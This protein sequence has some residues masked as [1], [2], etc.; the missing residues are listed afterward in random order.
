MRKARGGQGQ[1]PCGPGHGHHAEPE[2]GTQ[3][4]ACSDKTPAQR[5][6]AARLQSQD[7]GRETLV[8]ARSR[9]GEEDENASP[10]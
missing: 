1:T 8:P 4:G 10:T 5:G 3:G 6:R 2:A 7:C 9:R